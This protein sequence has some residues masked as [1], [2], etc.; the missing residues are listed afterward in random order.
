MATSPRPWHRQPA[1][2]FGGLVGVRLRFLHA[3]AEDRALR[4]ARRGARMDALVAVEACASR[5]SDSQRRM[6]RWRRCHASSTGAPRVGRG[7][8]SSARLERRTAPAGR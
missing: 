1:E 3:H 4:E 6:S 7:G 5:A 2:G 8:T